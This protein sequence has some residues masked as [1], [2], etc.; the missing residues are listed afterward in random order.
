MKSGSQRWLFAAL[1]SSGWTR[2]YNNGGDPG[3]RLL[4][5]NLRFFV[6]S[7]YY[8]TSGAPDSQ[9]IRILDGRVLA[10]PPLAHQSTTDEKP[11]RTPQ[12]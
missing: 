1:C 11:M 9:G 4:Y 2:C 5:C 10:A 6:A 12:E 8:S 3:A 7:Q